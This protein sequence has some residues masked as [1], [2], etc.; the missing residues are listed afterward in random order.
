MSRYV[1]LHR[2]GQTIVSLHQTTGCKTIL[3]HKFPQGTPNK[4]KKD[5][6]LDKHQIKDILFPFKTIISD[7]F[8]IAAITSTTH[9][10]RNKNTRNR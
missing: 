1:G 6:V 2:C 4:E 10:S 8:E 5:P 3:G 7:S 9:E